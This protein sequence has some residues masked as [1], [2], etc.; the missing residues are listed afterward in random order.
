MI[1]QCFLNFH[2]SVNCEVFL[3]LL[4]TCYLELDVFNMGTLMARFNFL[5]FLKEFLKV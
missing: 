4:R 2:S 5:I 1:K 3:M